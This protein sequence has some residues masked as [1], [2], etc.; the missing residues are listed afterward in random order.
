MIETR[1]L[2]RT[3]GGTDAV[4]DLDLHVRAGELFG[5]LGPNGAGKTTTIRMLC[6]LLR[7]SRGS[8]RIGGVDL[9]AD[10]AAARRLIG[11]APDVAPLY[12]YLTVVEYIGFVTSL[13][14]LAARERD[15]R[16]AVQIERLGLAER[17][18][19]LCKSLSHGMRKKVHLAAMFTVA[20]RILILDEPTSGLDPRSAR[21][22]KDVLADARDAGTTVFLSTH[23]LDV[24]EEICDRVGILHRGRM[25]ACGSLA[26]LRAQDASRSLED[27]FL[28]LTER[29]GEGDAAR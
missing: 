20:P 19:D 17:A 13:Y 11:Y 7:P 29:G 15:A 26:E 21:V 14:G 1:G 22:L 6:G 18:D 24:A 8:I 23:V 5:F 28:Q 12:E 16:T 9:R 25:L 2:T 10:A 27:V 3:F 4:R